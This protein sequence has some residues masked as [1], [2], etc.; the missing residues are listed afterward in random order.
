MHYHI[1]AEE[2]IR[3]QEELSMNE[4][5]QAQLKLQPSA[6]LEEKMSTICAFC[7]IVLEGYYDEEDMRILAGKCA[8]TLYE[9]RTNLVLG[10][11]H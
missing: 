5:L 1:F 7:G 4:A 3:L 9:V 6:P 10:T 8:Q 2:F 11:V